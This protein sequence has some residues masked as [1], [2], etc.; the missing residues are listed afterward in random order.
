[1][2]TEYLDTLA[3]QLAE[4]K[5]MSCRKAIARILE[6][7]KQECK[8]GVF[9]DAYSAEDTLMERVRREPTCSEPKRARRKPTRG[10]GKR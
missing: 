2:G 9:G 6:R 4:G 8:D 5:S 3:G 7:T 10:R 1:M